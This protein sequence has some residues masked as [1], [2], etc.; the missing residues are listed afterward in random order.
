[1]PNHGGGVRSLIGDIL[2]PLPDLPDAGL[3]S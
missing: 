1:M 3:L 2:V